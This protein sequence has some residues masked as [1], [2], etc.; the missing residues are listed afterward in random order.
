MTLP[1]SCAQ[2]HAA[3]ADRSSRSSM[4]SCAL[5]CTF[6]LRAL[7]PHPSK[8]K[9][10]PWV[11]ARVSPTTTFGSSLSTGLHSP[12]PTRTSPGSPGCACSTRSFRRSPECQFLIGPLSHRVID[13][14]REPP[15]NGS[16]HLF[17]PQRHHRIDLRRPSRGNVAGEQ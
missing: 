15:F 17:V 7:R 13:S 10:G 3:L 6:D 4:I 11:C 2:N 14:L 1:P 9:R 12:P 5:E 16:I 8:S